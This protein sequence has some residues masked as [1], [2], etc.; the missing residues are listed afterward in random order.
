ML[1]R[2]VA[3]AV[4]VWLSLSPSFSEERLSYWHPAAPTCGCGNVAG[5][6]DRHRPS[7]CHLPRHLGATA[8][9]SFTLHAVVVHLSRRFW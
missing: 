1:E 4:A 7:I 3:I 9:Q 5:L 2:T 6:T 8:Q